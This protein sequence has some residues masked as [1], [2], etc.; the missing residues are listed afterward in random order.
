MVILRRH[1]DGLTIPE[2]RRALLR[3]GRPGVLERD[4]E[5]IVRL[6]DFHRLPGGR[7]ILR[8]MEEAP[9]EVSGGEDIARPDQPFADHPSTLRDL[10]SLD[11]YVIFDV[12]TN[13]LD[14][15]TA[16]FFQLSAIKVVDGQAMESG[17]WY[18]QV[19]TGTITRALR[20]KL[21]FDELDLEAKIQSAGT[22]ADAMNAFCEFTGDLPLVAHNASFD[23][24]FLRKY[25]PDLSNHLV[26]SLELL[27]LAY[28]A[29]RSHS[30]ESLAKRF[31][32]VLYGERW[33]DVLALDDKLKISAGLGVEPGDLFHS[34][35]FD[36][37]VLHSLFQD[38]LGKLRGLS[39]EFKAQLRHI[40][41]ALGDL[42]AA[43]AAPTEPPEDLHAFISI[44]PWADELEHSPLPSL[45]SPFVCDGPSVLS[46]YDQ[47]LEKL[48]WHPRAAQQEMIRRVSRSLSVGGQTMIEASTGTG[49]TLAYLLPALVHARAGGDQVVVSTSTKT[50]QDQLLGD[51]EERIAPHLPFAFRYTVLKGQNN[52]L[53]L[54]KLWDAFLEAFYGEE[55]HQTPFEEKLALIYLLRYA[56]ESADGDLQN[57][58]YWLQNRFPI[59][60]YLKH[61]LASERETCGQVCDYFAYCFYPRAL[62]LANQA[63]LLIVNHALLL[64]RKWDEDYLFNLILDEAHNLEDVATNT[65]TEEASRA[66]IEHLLTRLMRP[67]EK[68]G[69]LLLARRWTP[70]STPINRA[71][72][73]VRRVRRRNRE[74]GGYLRE[75]LQR[76]G[77][78]FHPKYGASWRMR[79]A[80]HRANYFNWQHVQRALDE[81]L[82]E[83]AEI[84]RSLGVVSEQLSKVSDRRAGSLLRELQAIRALLFG[85]PEEP[86]QRTLLEE[87]PQ[88]GFD[89]LVMVHWIELGLR[90]TPDE[91]DIRPEQIIWAFK[92]APVRI[93]RHLETLIYQR[94]RAL[95]FTSA[96]LTLAEGGFNF[97]LE[98]LGLEAYLSVE[99]LVQLPKEFRYEDQVMLGLPGY[100]RNS[101]RYDQIARFQEE[102]AHELHCLFQFT[103]GRGLVLHTARARMEQVATYLEG[104]LTHLPVYW[105]REGVSTRLLKEEFEAREESVLLGVRSFWEGI[106]VP[107]PS[108]SYLVIEKLPFPVPG[109]PIIEAR[110]EEIRS[111]GGNEWM[112]YLIPLAT[113]HFKQ[114]FGRLM[115]KHDDHGVVIFMDK[116]LRGDTFYR[117]AV[118]RSLP[119]YK[120]TND[121]MDA[122]ENRE[123]F[124]QAIAEHMAPLFPDLADRIDLFPCIR[125]EA[126]PDIERLLQKCEL[127][128]CISQEAYL[129]YRDRL[130]LAA[131]ELIQGFKDFHPEQD[132]AMQ[133]ILAC[134]DTLVVLPTGSGKS[135]TFQLPALLRNGV[136]LVFSPLI[137]LMR[138]QV[139]KLRDK[140]LT[141]VDY[142]VS[143]QS[144]AHRDDVYR[145]MA[146]GDLRLVYI[147]PERIRDSALVEAL[148]DTDVI[149][150]VVDEAH[151]VHMWGH[152]FRPDFLSI[153]ELF[154]LDRPPIAAL[155]ATA[156]QETREGIAGAL[157]L[158]QG[159]NLVTKS[160]DRPELK[161]I[162][163]NNRSS[164]ERIASKR[165]KMRVLIK[166]LHAAQRQDETAII[167]TSTVRDA[168]HL[169]RSLNMHGFTV[170]HYHGRMAAQDREEVQEM[171]R[172]G[173]IRIIV[174]TKAF[175]MG[176]DKAD[177]RY[178][179][180]YNVPGDLESYFQ[181][182]G[183]AGRDGQTAYCVLLY[184][185]SDLG[186]QQYFIHSAFP[187]QDELNGLVQALR[188]RA[189]GH[190]S[191]LARPS[192]LALE[193][194]VDEERLDI[195]L[196]LL[197]RMGFVQRS[198]NFTLM[199]NL[200]LNRS[201]DWLSDQ[202][203]AND[204]VLFERLVTQAGISDKLGIQLDL[205]DSAATIAAD[206]IEIDQLLTRLSARGWAVYRP[207][208]R[209]YILSVKDKLT[210]G[211]QVH[212]G[213]ADIGV[214]Q[215]AMQ[216]NLKRMM[217]Y[218]ESLGSGD[219]RRAF[220]LEHFGETVQDPPSPCCDLCDPS[221]PLP[222]R[223]I[224]AEAVKDLPAEV[225]PAYITLRAV[226]WNESRI[227]L[228]Y[229]QPYTDKTLA[230]ILVGNAFAAAHFIG[231]PI[232]RNRRIKR[233]ERSPYY[234]V[235]Q[236][237]R[238]G[239]KTILQILGRLQTEGY[240][241]P[242]SITFTSTHDGEVTYT[243]PVLTEKGQLQV[244]SGKYLT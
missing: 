193:S 195:S 132:Q 72:G 124:Y 190:A 180:H 49:K 197:E 186:T 73:A 217:Q 22:Q 158:N 239:E 43:P 61:Q 51:L 28:P 192:D 79:A 31:G 155:T 154:S 137:A 82:H 237:V 141:L 226:E 129:E 206:P 11:A 151:C 103:E 181:E 84:N 133:A 204:A 153:R 98:R 100:F 74:F 95:V 175:G 167:Y 89:P 177:V 220:I 27:I 147:A 63:D 185:R 8:E 182:A 7:I 178:V 221:M 44:T 117:E 126:I 224:P 96:T 97:F 121:D 199:A 110:R 104:S 16:D 149:Q 222:W 15:S 70:D 83:L 162:V 143:G 161:F 23:I 140:G 223:D 32:L 109:D 58:S 229:A 138:D 3:M 142:I 25:R 219:C 35:I 118:L 87:I 26:D 107:G 6:S 202:L 86:G 108:L 24:G 12:E 66:I 78:R 115:R 144:G 164:P 208:E 48:S 169:S 18:A 165:D 145:R 242:E 232:E 41:P 92:R 183:R 81:I 146:R 156:T 231:D 152:S 225:D 4:I 9:S 188:V 207:W 173:I 125:E 120:R 236:G 94:S 60:G 191:I 238:G 189:D 112:G 123:T 168:E 38:A 216:R 211:E 14:P 128:R 19:D 88:V 131:S 39:P 55:A 47:L 134:Q 240:T 62:A 45:S 135:L 17:D 157:T 77:I 212:L 10:P 170:R 59:L 187:E 91:E 53:C 99:D 90:G 75:F 119:G 244:Q 111:Q 214:L 1:A 114:G 172:E 234:G 52:Y 160:V 218:G 209:G 203:P 29:F 69:L 201:P 159:Y 179:I 33:S 230:R 56:E 139:D 20:D 150:I 227:R 30:I 196:H 241:R 21:H 76:Q 54:T 102:M 166:I 215:G 130:L 46:L 228:D 40:S 68:R 71:M 113:L 57:T 106:D 205:L 184:H 37:L 176:I 101:A 163:Y 127:P 67:D 2:I 174:A 235:L 198:F 36:C 80:P 85:T 105:Q 171:F 233:L 136:T 5:Q 213:Q 148:R 210:Q 64:T 122:E 42:I 200:L 13:G 34:A 50:L 243:A 93:A 65:L 194:G 116:R